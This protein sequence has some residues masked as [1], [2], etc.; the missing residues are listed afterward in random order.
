[1]HRPIR[2]IPLA[3]CCLLLAITAGC[4]KDDGDPTIEAQP[5]IAT[6]TYLVSLGGLGDNSY[7]DAAAEAIFGFAKES[8]ARLRLLLPHSRTEA[9]QMWT[10]WLSDNAEQDSAVLIVGGSEYEQMVQRQ[11]V[12][13]HN[14]LA[15]MHQRGS[16]MLIF[17]SD[18]EIEGIS[19]VR[20][21]RYGAAY[22]CGAMSGKFD[23]Y[24]LAAMQDDAMLKDA[25]SGFTDGWNAHHEEGLHV[26]VQYLADD[27][28]G[29]AMPDS[30]YRVM[31]T[32]IRQAPLL[33]QEMVFPILGG[34]NF[35]VLRAMNDE[36]A[37]LGLVIGMDVDQSIVSSRVPF[38]MVVHIG[39]VVHRYLDDWIAGRDW[40]PTCTVDMAE[41]GAEVLLHP[42]FYQRG[43]LMSDLYA[44]PDTFWRLYEQYKDEAIRKENE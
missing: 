17:E 11:A 15:A 12:T 38:S 25:I 6:V 1:M 34:S 14:Q 16:R 44:D 26:T 35:G 39:D 36:E 8:G 23:A 21:S 30:A 5:R 13:Y 24:I 37:N 18:A 22:L 28:A 32:R 9:E 27:E 10:Q 33:Y 19:T 42:S 31:M 20:V 2:R 40:L 4:S 7:N 29:F 43:T 41:G 3:V